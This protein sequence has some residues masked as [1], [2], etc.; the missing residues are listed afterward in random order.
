MAP[1]APF[2]PSW[3]TVT[4]CL[5]CVRPMIIRESLDLRSSRSLERQNTAM[6]S[7]AASRA[8]AAGSRAASIATVSARRLRWVGPSLKR[9]TVARSHPIPD[10]AVP[11]GGIR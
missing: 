6:V 3:P 8:S 7:V 4:G 10:D 1:W 2:G 9:G 5:S 11:T